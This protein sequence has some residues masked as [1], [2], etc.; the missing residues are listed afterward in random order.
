MRLI[1]LALAS[2]LVLVGVGCSMTTQA[3]NFNGLSTPDG[4]ATH[5]STTNV[6]VHLLFTDPV[7]GDASLP[8]TVADHTAAIKAAGMSK[9]RIVQSN[10]NTLWWVLPPFSFIAQPV[11]TNVASD[12]T[13]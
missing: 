13:N 6:A 4:T 8:A 5:F 9:V 11:V 10:V 1:A 2:T 12:A 7:W 3:S